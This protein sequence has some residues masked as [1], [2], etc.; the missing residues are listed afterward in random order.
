MP[1]HEQGIKVLGT[2]LGLED[3]MAAHVESVLTEHHIFISRI[4]TVK[5]VQSAWLWLLNLMERGCLS[6]R[7]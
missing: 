3:F 5:D 6:I 2:P 4:S 1:T 7:S